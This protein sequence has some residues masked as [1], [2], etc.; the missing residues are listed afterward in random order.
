MK[1]FLG[2]KQIILYPN[3]KKEHPGR[4]LVDKD[5]QLINSESKSIGLF[6]FYIFCCCKNN[7]FELFLQSLFGIINLE[8]LDDQIKDS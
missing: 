4:K 8:E 7:K 5:T 3:A 6:N 1:F 2:H